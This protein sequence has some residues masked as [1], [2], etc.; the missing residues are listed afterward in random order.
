MKKRH[1]RLILFLFV[2]VF[3]CGTLGALAFLTFSKGVNLGGGIQLAAPKDLQQLFLSAYL[4]FRA[5]DLSAPAGKDSTPIEF[6]IKP[7]ESVG[8]VANQLLALRLIKDT[9]L[10]RRYLQ[11]N[12]QDASMEAGNFELNQS[13]SIP[14]IA[15]ALQKGKIEEVSVT[16]PEGKRIEEV[17]EIVAQ[18]VPI[19]ATE[20]LALAK[21]PGPWKAQYPFLNELPPRA[22]LEGY[23]FPDTYN[24]PKDKISARDLINRMLSNFNAKMTAQIRSDIQASGRTLWDVVRLASIIEREAQRAEERPTIAGVYS[25]RLTAG[26]ALD[27]DPTVQYALGNTREPGQWWP[28][29]TQDDYQGVQSPYNL[30]LNVDLPPGPIANAGFSALKAAAYPEKNAYYFFRASCAQDGTHVFAKTFE[31]QISHACQ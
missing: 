7:N 4:N 29:I 27:A 19:T 6:T 21:D 18:Q 31:E 26:M 3:V 15:Q 1:R 17:A 5:G 16:I 25:N 22:T 9:E 11:Y 23:L 20:F 13:M 14:Q 8:E 30:Y 12:G 2:V 28:Q 24:L 10:F